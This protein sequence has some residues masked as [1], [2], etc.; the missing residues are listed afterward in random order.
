MPPIILIV[1]D[2]DTVRT[3]LYAWL[4]VS[5]P[6]HRVIA[7]GSGEEAVAVSETLSPDVVVMDISLPGISGI[8]AARLI[9][10]HSHE[11]HIIILTIHEEE[12]YR[13]DAASAGASAFVAKRLMQRQLLPTIQ[14]YLP[15]ADK[16][17]PG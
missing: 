3:S 15:P 1:E 16:G 6:D 10:N 17:E 13:A 8:E 14:K 12:A 9:K 2:H 5:F 4:S 7:I 11:S